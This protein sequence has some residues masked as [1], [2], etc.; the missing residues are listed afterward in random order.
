MSDEVKLL[1]ALKRVVDPELMINV[2][3]LGLVY[4]VRQEEDKVHVEMTLTSPAC[5]AGP[6]ILQQ[7]KMALENLEDVAEA[8]IKLVMSPPLDSRPHDR[9]S[10]RS[11]RDFLGPD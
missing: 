10:P 3:D 6:Q 4:S 7:A 2:V 1:E 9:R 11:A 5:P 8:N